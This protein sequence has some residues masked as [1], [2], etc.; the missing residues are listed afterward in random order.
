MKTPLLFLP[1][2]L[3]QFIAF[4]LLLISLSSYAQNSPAAPSD[5]TATPDGVSY[6]ITLN[7]SDN[8]DDET[9]FLIVR[10]DP[11]IC[12]QYINV[13]ANSTSYVDTDVL[14][15][16]EY[17]YTLSAVNDNGASDQVYAS[18][19]ITVATPPAPI[20]VAASTGPLTKILVT[21]TDNSSLESYYE[22]QDSSN[23]D[24]YGFYGSTLVTGGAEGSTVSKYINDEPFNVSPMHNHYPPNTTVYIRVRA[25]INDNGNLIHGPF[26][27]VVTAVTRDYPALP[28]QLQ[29]SE[30]SGHVKLT[31]QDNSDNEGKFFISRYKD[32]VTPL[33]KFVADSNATSFVDPSAEL[34]TTYTYRIQALDAYEITFPNE[35]WF[36]T[37]GRY[38][39]I[40]GAVQS[41]LLA[42]TDLTAMGTSPLS[43]RI[44]FTDTNESEDAYD[45]HLTSADDPNHIEIWT[46][47]GVAGSGN[48]IQ[49]EPSYDFGT[50][51]VYI[52]IRAFTYDPGTD[53]YTF[54]P[55]SETVEATALESFPVPPSDFTAVPEGQYIRLTWTDNSAPGDEFDEAS[56]IIMRADDGGV[57]Y[58]TLF[59]LPAN[60]TTF[61][62]ETVAP[63]QNYTYALE[64]LNE[65]EQGNEILVASATAAPATLDAPVATLATF[66]TSTS[67]T[68]N[69]NAVEGADYYKL[70]VYTTKDST[71]AAGYQGL[72]VNGTSAPVTGLKSFRKYLYQV[73]AFNDWAESDYSNTI[74]V[75][76]I[77]NL[78]LRTVCSPEPDAYRRWKIVNNNP[79]PVE[80]FWRVMA[81]NA[82][83]ITTAL[84]GESFFET[85]AAFGDYYSL[86]NYTKITWLDDDLVEHNSLKSSTQNQCAETFALGAVDGIM[87][88]TYLSMDVF[89]NP[90]TTTFT[91]RLATP[92]EEDVSL[93]IVNL[94]GKPMLTKTVAPN[95]DVEVDAAEYPA[96]MYIVKVA[97]GSLRKTIKV[98]RE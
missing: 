91:I 17:S 33:F 67:F 30:E 3:R 86:I 8:S 37:E 90:A 61:L 24:A 74:R 21:L 28:S 45:V 39:E 26:S 85:P 15:N 12:C 94:H 13:A 44:T 53:T 29:L 66:V 2:L 52:K 70:Y 7:W 10:E 60:T 89:P 32:N 81:S 42:P 88:A 92:Y 5:L 16:V 50:S 73:K 80:V 75:A 83:G 9:E 49:T 11:E 25:V 59:T 54:G 65:F 72:I 46:V 84:P 6:Q 93:E 34:N 51:L 82:T 63:G 43:F 18:A 69:W 96:G 55:F 98:I 35:H 31:W 76:K 36:F 41:G 38:V 47:D 62:D 20:N 77:K 58:N 4:W 19:T 23:P 56:F 68:A 14:P 79:F 27:P 1:H 64:A 57:N 40:T 48:T 95:K 97:Q 22:I 71:Y 87:E 78:T